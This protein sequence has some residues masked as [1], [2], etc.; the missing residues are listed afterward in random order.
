MK[1]NCTSCTLKRNG[2]WSFFHLSGITLSIDWSITER[3]AIQGTKENSSQ[4]HETGLKR[5]KTCSFLSSVA[6]SGAKNP[7]STIAKL[8]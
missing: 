7:D 1:E 3:Q 5:G 4:T 2:S 6:R 8:V